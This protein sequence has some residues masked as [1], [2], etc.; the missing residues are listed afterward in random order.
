M[1]SRKIWDELIDFHNQNRQE[2]LLLDGARQVGKTYII[3]AFASQYYRHF[4]E[5]NFLKNPTAKSLFYGIWNENDFYIKLSY[6]SDSPLVP[7][8]TLIFFDEVQECPEAV[9]YIK[10]LVDAGRFRY[11]LSGSLLGIELKSVRSAPVGYMRELTMF[12][13]DFE[14]FAHAVGLSAEQLGYVRQ[15][16]E[17]GESI[18]ALIHEK[19]MKVFRLYLVVG[20]MPAAVQAYLDTQNIRD[21][22]RVQQ[23]I[24]AEYKKDA[25]RYD[26]KNKMNII[27]VMELLP[28]EL[29]R[30][31]KRFYVTAIKEKEKFERLEDNFIWLD[32]AGIAIPVYNV[33]EPRIPLELAKKANLFKLFMN[34]VGLLAAQYMDGI[35]IRLLNGEIDVNFGAVFENFAAQELHAHGY[36]TIYYFNSKRHGEVDFLIER[37]G[38]VLPLEIKSGADYHKHAALNNMMQVQ[39]YALEKAIVY[40]SYNEVKPGR[41]T[42][43]PIYA[44]SFLHHDNLPDNLI[45]K[46]DL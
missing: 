7:G 13:L 30:E 45:Y 33:D 19:I 24:L 15:C 6:L 38:K 31:N 18:D 46:L 43:L 9:T 16:I 12:P 41:Q 40:S 10:F 20:G 26:E 23:G 32:K 35:Q 27:R 4:V 8:E 5:I 34:D 14:E 29:N 11:I 25:S 28:S 1:I 36:R 42:Y 2:A 17:H 21:V 39:D 22:I 3:R 37:D 44:L